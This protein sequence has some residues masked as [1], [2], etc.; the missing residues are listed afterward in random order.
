M[1]GRSESGRCILLASS[2][3]IGKDLTDICNHFKTD[4]EV[5][6]SN[7]SAL[8]V[9]MDRNEAVFAMLI[10]YQ[11]PIRGPDLVKGI[12]GLNKKVPI[13]VYGGNAGDIHHR[14]FPGIIPGKYINQF[15]T[16]GD[17]RQV[18]EFKIYR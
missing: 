11:L 4:L 9:F 6:T 14:L 10:H 7:E 8:A 5:V 15:P 17:M 12:R 1:F 13:I 16:L 18:L 2:S 3:A